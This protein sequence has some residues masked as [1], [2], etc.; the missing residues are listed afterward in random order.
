MKTVIMQQAEKI[1]SH[2]DNESMAVVDSGNQFQVLGG[3]SQPIDEELPTIPIEDLFT[4]MEATLMKG[5][6]CNDKMP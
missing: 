5:M 3:E 6:P 4:E 2:S 1:K